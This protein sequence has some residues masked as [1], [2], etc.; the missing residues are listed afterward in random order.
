MHDLH[1][2]DLGSGDGHRREAALRGLAGPAPDSAA[3]VLALRRLNDWVPQVRAAARDALPSLAHASD[4]DHVVDALC[5]L[6]PVWM[7]WG[8]AQP[9]DKA[10]AQQIIAL[11]HVAHALAGRLMAT[12]CGPMPIVLAQC[13]RTPVLDD[14][15]QA[16]AKQALQPGVRALAHGT[17]I[18]ARATW[19]DGY[20]WHWID[21]REAKG[22]C[23]SVL[24]QRALARRTP[25][26][27]ALNDAAADRSPLVR[28]MAAKGL[29]DAMATLGQAALPLA[30]Q[31]A[32]DGSPRI[33]ERGAFVLH[34]L[35]MPAA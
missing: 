14:H 3:V 15:L 25:L 18:K 33:A 24:G 32:A 28:R 7:H 5:S 27:Q 21:L 34:R 1:W 11:P 13:L 9:Q 17:L 10:V 20:R 8:R 4:P 12:A 2:N 6:L 29:V 16:M 19:V 35:Q 22:R 30:R 31:L 23:V 26:L